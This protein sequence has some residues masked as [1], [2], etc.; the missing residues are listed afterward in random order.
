VLV[1]NQAKYDGDRNQKGYWRLERLRKYSDRG[2][3][4]AVPPRTTVRQATQRLSAAGITR[5]TDVTQLDRL[6]I[7]NFMSVRPNDL[8]PGISYYN[9][10]GTTRDDAHA[11][12]IM[13]AIERH[14]GEYCNYQ[15]ISGTY[16]ALKDTAKCVSPRDIV[17]PKLCAYSDDLQLDWVCGF[18]LIGEEPV[19]VPLNCVVTPYAPIAGVELFYSSTNGLASGNSLTEALCHALCEVVERDAE[20]MSLSRTRLSACVRAIAFPD[21]EDA[22]RVPERTI[23][24]NSLPPRATRLVNKMKRAGLEVLLNDQTD[25]SN[26]ATI[27]C[28]IVDPNWSG[29]VNAHG[30]CG[31]HPDSRV[32]LLRA[33]TEAAQSRLTC[34]QG[35]REDLTQIM[36]NK[37]WFGLDRLEQRRRRAE[38]V[39]FAEIPTSE[40]EYIDDDVRNVLQRLP[41]CGLSQVIAFDLTHPDIGIPVVRVVVPKAETWAVFHVHT[42]RGVLGARGVEVLD[43]A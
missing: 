33:L 42:G 17:V 41:S 23:A 9:G 3:V 31:A 27:H 43:C 2:V 10:K 7:P 12:A 26:I 8:N 11:G 28:T 22:P 15:I 4:R 5:V 35:G 16:R 13:E 29:P 1:P 19:L 32:A 20:A 39:D 21:A 36:R 40:N 34:I 14:A 38:S 18:N 30:G 37:T 25:K 6:G 24:I